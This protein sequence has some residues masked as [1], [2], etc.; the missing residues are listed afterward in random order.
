MVIPS[1]TGLYKIIH[2]NYH[3]AILYVGP[4]RD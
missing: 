3:A 2:L 4:G 1:H